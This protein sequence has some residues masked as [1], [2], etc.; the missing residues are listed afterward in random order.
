MSELWDDVEQFWADNDEW[1]WI[2]LA[3]AVAMILAVLVIGLAR[4]KKRDRDRK[5]A[6]AIRHEAALQDA[7]I[8]RKDAET[9]RLE[10]QADE[11]QAEADRLHALAQERRR[12]LE[13]DRA[14]QVARLH[15]AEKLEHGSKDSSSPE[16]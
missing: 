4:A 6:E 9:R 13:H 15:K 12:Q 7:V 11:A 10:A 3:A 2:V 5:H 16:H 8:G 14:E 1:I